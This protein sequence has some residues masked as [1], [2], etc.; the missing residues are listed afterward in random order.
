MSASTHTPA[1]LQKLLGTARAVAPA[2]TI[3]VAALALLPAAASATPSPLAFNGTITVDTQPTGP[4]PAG[5][6]TNTGTW[7]A[8][9]LVTEQFAVSEKTFFGGGNSSTLHYVGTLTGAAGTITI[10]VQARFVAFAAPYEYVRGGWAITSGTGAYA[11]LHGTGDYA[12]TLNIFTTPVTESLT[13]FGQ[14]D[15]GS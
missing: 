15:S 12:A 5:G 6:I 1:S 13:G 3:A 14:Y 2:A 8:S 4:G 10:Q 7:T 11:N 9:G